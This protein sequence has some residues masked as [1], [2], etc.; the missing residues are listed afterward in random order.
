MRV[1]L[2][3]DYLRVGGTERQTLFLA[4]YL[5]EQGD[6]VTLVL[7][8][9][10][11]PL[12]PEAQSLPCAVYVLQRRDT[13]LPLWA[14]GLKE[15]V[16]ERQPEIVIAMGRTANCYA[17]GLQHAL[18]QTV[19]V[20]TLRT[21]KTLFPLHALSLKRVR[22]VIANSNWWRRR[23]REHGIPDART[24]VIHNP[25]LLTRTA[26]TLRGL[27]QPT[28][29]AHNAAEDTCVFLTVAAFRRGKRHEEMLRLLPQWQTAH[30]TLAWQLWLVGDGKER[31]KCERLTRELGLSTH[32]HF[33]GF[34]RDPTPFY[35][36]ADV[37]LSNSLE[38]SL[39]NFLVEAQAAGLPVIARDFRGVRECFDPGQTGIIVAPH[40]DAA[41]SEAL[42]TLATDPAQ[43][44]AMATGAPAFAEANFNAEARAEATRA[45][46]QAQ[47]LGP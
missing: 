30:P 8:R 44:Q 13:H 21:G 20:G 17:G 33:L 35:A 24:T 7:F 46:L 1:V 23:M 37:A 26:G 31:A 11:G 38:D 4:R 22:A 14:P 45:F 42:T 5:A 18:P 15:A 39:P 16:E 40:D 41:M 6:D 32:V 10:G 29:Q 27:R 19:V 12:W 36:G 28:R 34:Q 43:R 25:M 9:P 2:L 3:Q 47:L